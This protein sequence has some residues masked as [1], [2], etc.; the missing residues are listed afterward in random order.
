MISSH[1]VICSAVA[2][3][4]RWRGG[5]NPLQAS[6][7]LVKTLL[8]YLEGSRS[9]SVKLWARLGI[10][11]AILLT[12]ASCQTSDQPFWGLAP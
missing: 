5:V 3:P 2:C 12:H 8:I 9:K 10:H 4:T 1:G 6:C 11:S 7:V